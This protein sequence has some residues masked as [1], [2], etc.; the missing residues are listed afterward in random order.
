MHGVRVLR[1][2]VRRTSADHSAERLVLGDLP[3]DVHRAV[4]HAA[5]RFERAGR[6]A[7]PDDHGVRQRIARRDAEREQRSVVGAVR[8]PYRIDKIGEVSG[9]SERGG[10]SGQKAAAGDHGRKYQAAPT[11]RSRCAF[12]LAQQ[13]KEEPR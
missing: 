7:G 3:L 11:E 10:G 9:K 2:G 4:A 6:E 13:G 8:Y 12:R 1:T 5:E